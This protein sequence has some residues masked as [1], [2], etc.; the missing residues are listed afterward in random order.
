MIDADVLADKLRDILTTYLTD[1]SSKSDNAA[2]QLTTSIGHPAD[3]DEFCWILWAEV[4]SA[5]K[6]CVNDATATRDEQIARLVAV[7]A[8]IKVQPAPHYDSAERPRIDRGRILWKD[9][10]NLGPQMR[11]MWNGKRPVV[12]R[13]VADYDFPGD[14]IS[15]SWE[16]LNVFAA[17][18]TA[19]DVADFALYGLWAMRAALEGECNRSSPPTAVYTVPI[20]CLWVEHAGEALRLRADDYGNAGRGGSLWRSQSGFCE[21]RWAFWRQQLKQASKDIELP[22]AIRRQ[23]KEAAARMQ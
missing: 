10:P 23:A 3:D 6:S 7:V 2:R 22:D 12:S 4:C 11:E 16:R 14:D 17:M 8:A 21:E 18:L 19:K 20:A 5:V 15:P 1:P 13:V 9:L